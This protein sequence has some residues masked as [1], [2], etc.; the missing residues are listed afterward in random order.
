MA[1]D[2][3]RKFIFYWSVN[4]KFIPEDVFLSNE[5]GLGLLAVTLICWLGFGM[6]KWTR[7]AGL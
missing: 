2:L 3:G 6:F 1:F 5:W 4:W 7:F